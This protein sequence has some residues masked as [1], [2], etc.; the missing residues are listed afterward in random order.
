MGI[1]R[2]N[3][4][5]RV[6]LGIGYED[7]S[8][9]TAAIAE[10]IFENLRFED[11]DNVNKSFENDGCTIEF[12]VIGGYKAYHRDARY[13]VSFGNWLPPEDEIEFDFDKDYVKYIIEK[14]YEGYEIDLIVSEI[15]Y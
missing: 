9:I 11:I 1:S 3:F 2:G 12:N 14:A 8:N 7:N 15:E 4:K 5:I 10:E 6:E 13:D